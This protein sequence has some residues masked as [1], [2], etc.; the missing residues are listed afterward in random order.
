MSGL[1]YKLHQRGGLVVSLLAFYSDD[2]SSNLAGYLNFLYEK[3]KMNKKRPGLAHLLKYLFNS[4]DNDNLQ[5]CDEIFGSHK[6][7]QLWSIF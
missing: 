7:S 3:T 2:P 6:I 5:L 4:S 1:Y